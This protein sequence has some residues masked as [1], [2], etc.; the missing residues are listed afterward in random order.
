MSGIRTNAAAELL[1]VSPNTLRCWERRFGYPDAA[2]RRRAAT[3]STTWPSSRRCAARCSRRTTSPPPIQ[4]ARQRGEGPAPRRA[5]SRPSTASTTRSPTASWR[6]ASPSARSSARWRSCCCPRVE[7]A[8]RR[9]TAARP[10]TSSP[11]AGRPAGCTPRGASPRRPPAPRASCCS[12]RA[13]A[14]PR[15]AARPGARA[16]AA[17]RRLPRAAP[18]GEPRA[19]ARSRA[20]CARS[21]RRALVLCGTRRDARRG[22]PP[23]LRGA[24]DRLGRRAVYEYREAMPVTGDHAIP[25][26]GATPIEAPSSM[27]A[28]R[29][30]IA[31]TCRRSRRGAHGARRAAQHAPDRP[32]PR[33]ASPRDARDRRF[34]CPPGA[35]GAAASGVERPPDASRRSSSATACPRPASRRW[36]CSPRPAASWSCAPCAAASAGPKANAPARSPPTLE[37]HAAS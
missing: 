24:P 11:A 20:R 29:R 10:S 22:R 17:A 8:A 21:T 9:A 32:A 4:V 19:G 37:R 12:T 28:R 34:A 31:S 5:C 6:R 27:K 18:V 25:S 16:R 36:W 2:P 26:I 30:R 13:R 3:A 1:G 15:V 7:L 33:L 23:R 35:R 14:R